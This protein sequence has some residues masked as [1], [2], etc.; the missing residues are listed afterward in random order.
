MERLGATYIKL[1]QMMSVR[2]DVLPEPALEQLRILQDN[3]QQFDTATAIA[4]IES[5]LGGPL[6]KFFSEISPEPVAAASLAQVYKARLL[7]GRWVAVK[8]QRPHCLETVSKDLYV[9]RRAAEVYQGLMRRFAPNQRTNYVALLNE[10][11][12]GFYTELDFVNEAANQKF[13]KKSLA[14]EGVTGIYVPEIVDALTTRRILVSEWVNGVK[15]SA[16]SPAQIKEVT[17]DAQEA[18]LTM[19]LK[20]GCMHADPHPG[21]IQ[22]LDNPKEMGGGKKAKIA[23]L[24]FGLVARI[25]KED[26]DKMVS[27]IIHLANKDYRSLVRDFQRLDILGSRVDPAI[28]VP[29]MDKALTPYIKGGGAKKY[30]EEVLKTYGLDSKNIR[31]NTGGFA[32]MT[33][34]ALTV[35]NDIPFSIPPYFALLGRAII[36]LEG[37]ALT[38]NPSYGLIMESYPFVARKLLNSDRPELQKALQ[39]FL[40]AGSGGKKS[41]SGMSATRLTVLLNSALD[42][43]KK[44]STNAVDFDTLPDETVSLSQALKFLCSD[45]AG[46]LRD[47]LTNE[48]VQAADVLLRQATR[49]SYGSFLNRLPRIPLISNLL[50]RPEDVSLLVP[51]PTLKA[52]PPS[53]KGSASLSTLPTIDLSEVRPAFVSAT[54]LIETAAPKL[55]LEEEL[56]AISLVDLAKETS[57]DDVVTMISGDSLTD[58]AAVAQL[59]VQFINSGSISQLLPALPDGVKSTVTQVASLCNIRAARQHTFSDISAA[60]DSLTAKERA[61]FEDFLAVVNYRLRQ[62]LIMRLQVLKV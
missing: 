48:G 4:Q 41:S 1:G 15:L 31:A 60:L 38:G 9:L 36:T 10:W 5:E 13:L 58:P 24:D 45:K 11:A 34:D 23:L 54:K 29:L 32:A 43:I 19:L 14:E 37:V 25:T 59:L 44:D 39:E 57:C 26:Q 35:M 17:P 28:V 3:V 33:S 47:L 51:I 40:Y 18:F 6:G 20:I 16:C 22:Y 12:I 49:K 55:S 7:D 2:P 61:V 27:A 56:Y 50:P 8:V 52:F 62:K 53:A 42:V 21:N 30:R 46:N